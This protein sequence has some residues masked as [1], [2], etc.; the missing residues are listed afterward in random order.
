MNQDEAQKR[1][2]IL[3]DQITQANKAYFAEDREIVPES[4]RDQLKAELIELETQYPELI[5]PHSPTQRVGAPLSGKLPKVEH[6]KKKYSLGDAFDAEELREFDER[7]KRFLK[8][9]S[10]EY[11]CE[12]KID[13]LNITLWYHHGMLVKALTRGDGSTGEDVTHSIKTIHNL[14]LQLKEPLTLEVA[15]EVFITKQDF[16]AI[17]A[18]SPSIPLSQGGGSTPLL[19]KG[20]AG[21]GFLHNNSRNRS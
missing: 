3:R 15:G 14:P 8:A 20:G 19:E 13:G 9:E 16:A 1:I 12:L 11:S 10:V 5:T 21:G 18:K 2:L 4:V 7:V 6:K 17:N